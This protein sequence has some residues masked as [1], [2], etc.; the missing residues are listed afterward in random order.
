LR[1]CGI[2][3]W[4]WS[5][6]EC[7]VA[8][9]F[10]VSQGAAEFFQRNS[11][12]TSC[13]VGFPKERTRGAAMMAL[14]GPPDVPQ[15]LIDDIVARQYDI[16][17][18]AATVAHR[19]LTSLPFTPPRGK[20]TSRQREVLEWVAEGKTS[21]DIATIMGL[22]PPTVEKHLRLARETLGVE[23]TAHALIKAA[24]LNQVFIAHDTVGF[25]STALP[26]SAEKP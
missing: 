22:S 13:T 9:D 26:A 10:A 8:P 11:L 16:I 25:D 7:G 23:T 3:P 19:M 4:S 21:A 5:A 17:F 2:A 12:V 1:N 6:A 18:V 14:V 24:F 15:A 20:L